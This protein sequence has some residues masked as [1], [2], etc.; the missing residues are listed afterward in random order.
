MF[1]FL[2]FLLRFN[3]DHE[4]VRQICTHML[5]RLGPTHGRRSMNS[6]WSASEPWWPWKL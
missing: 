6:P 2:S 3:D 5:G 1:L 4:Q